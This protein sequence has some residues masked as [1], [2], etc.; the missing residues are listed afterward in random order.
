MLPKPY[1]DSRG[2]RP[3][4]ADEGCTCQ[5]K[6]DVRCKL[7]A[8]RDILRAIRWENRVGRTLEIAGHTISDSLAW[9]EPRWLYREL[10]KGAWWSGGHTGNERVVRGCLDIA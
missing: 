4:G 3:Y 1:G 9:G 7:E 10:V 2:R 6:G 8:V 5:M